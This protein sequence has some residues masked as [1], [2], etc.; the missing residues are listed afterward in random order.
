MIFYLRLDYISNVFPYLIESILSQN[1]IKVLGF[2]VV[3]LWRQEAS[4]MIHQ[5]WKPQIRGIF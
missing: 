5:I 1:L 4:H 3:F 2:L